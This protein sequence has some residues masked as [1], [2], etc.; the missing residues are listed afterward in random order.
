MN[1]LL[2]S[3]LLLLCILETH[4][5]RSNLHGS[6]GSRFAL[7]AKR[8]PGVSR[9]ERMKGM[10]N[11]LPPLL[12]SDPEEDAISYAILHELLAEAEASGKLDEPKVGALLE[13]KV[14]HLGDEGASVDIGFRIAAHLPLSEMSLS[15][16]RRARDVVS[17]GQNLTVE[18][19]QMS[20]QHVPIISIKKLALQSAWERILKLR[21]DDEEFNVTV[22]DIN[23]GGAICIACE[24]RAFL[25]ASHL[26]GNVTQDLKGKVLTVSGSDRSVSLSTYCS[27]RFLSLLCRA[28]PTT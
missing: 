23:R 4:S 11:E 21:D 19:V 10:M 26:N 8:K 17:V 1:A 13:G 9:L 27:I 28:N 25:P 3:I 12:R 6:F 20:S 24:L 14:L 7:A 15:P 18:V 16:V 2:L 5:W 22:I